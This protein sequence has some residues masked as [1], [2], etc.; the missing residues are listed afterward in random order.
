MKF[1]GEYLKGYQYLH[2]WTFVDDYSRFG[3][4]C[5]LNMWLLSH[6]TATILTITQY[7]RDNAVYTTIWYKDDNWYKEDKR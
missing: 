1:L 4:P 5:D 6:P 2:T 7:A 3:R